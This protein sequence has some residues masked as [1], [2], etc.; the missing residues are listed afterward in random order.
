MMCIACP[1]VSSSSSSSGGTGQQSTATGS[2]TGDSLEVVVSALNKELIGGMHHVLSYIALGLP[3]STHP[4][5]I[6]P[7]IYHLHGVVFTSDSLIFVI[8]RFYGSSSLNSLSINIGV[9]VFSGINTFM[10]L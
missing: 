3:C 8:D 2:S 4:L 5:S 10:L 7:Y 1:Y 9:H 6:L